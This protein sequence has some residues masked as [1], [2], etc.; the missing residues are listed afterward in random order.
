MLLNYF[1]KMSK[2]GKMIKWGKIYF[3]IIAFLLTTSYKAQ[4]TGTDIQGRLL[5]SKATSFSVWPSH[6]IDRKILRTKNFNWV[7]WSNCLSS[8][9]YSLYLTMTPIIQCPIRR[10]F[11]PPVYHSLLSSPFLLFFEVFTRNLILMGS[12]NTDI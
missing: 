12:T 9:S 10:C 11:F 2:L 8:L 1:L 6:W 4:W 7:L 3:D 5:V